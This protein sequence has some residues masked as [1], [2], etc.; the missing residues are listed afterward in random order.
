MK[1]YV[2]ADRFRCVGKAWEIRH[3]LRSLV[4]ENKPE[5]TLSDFLA[6]RPF[7]SAGSRKKIARFRHSRI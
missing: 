6:G 4:K 7:H 5:Q 2:T 1:S 3:Y